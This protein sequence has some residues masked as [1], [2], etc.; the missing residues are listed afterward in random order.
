MLI[1]L[2]VG[3]TNVVIPAIN[4]P[5]I[6]ILFLVA[7]YLSTISPEHFVS[8]IFNL[9]IFFFPSPIFMTLN[10]TFCPRI[11]LKNS[12]YNFLIFV[13]KQKIS[14]PNVGPHGALKRYSYCHD[15]F[16]KNFMNIP[17]YSSQKVVVR[18][19]KSERCINK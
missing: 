2:A 17:S 12:C 3:R 14:N 18:I 7:R 10:C 15:S 16:Q 4:C 11:K 13:F 1:S 19:V 6:Q 9:N 8:K 5:A